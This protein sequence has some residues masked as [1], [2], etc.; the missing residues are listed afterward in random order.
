[1]SEKLALD[2]AQTNAIAAINLETAEKAMELRSTLRS[3]DV[4]AFKTQLT[5][6]YNQRD[7]D[8]RSLLTQNQI[9]DYNA[10]KADMKALRDNAK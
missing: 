10:T 9:A 5:A 2:V 8:I 3:T 4:R 7:A 6:L 1:M